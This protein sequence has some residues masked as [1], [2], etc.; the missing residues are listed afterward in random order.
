MQLWQLFLFLSVLSLGLH[1]WQRRAIKGLVAKVVANTKTAL[2][3]GAKIDS[4]NFTL[5]EVVV[6]FSGGGGFTL[7]CKGGRL[8]RSP[9][10]RTNPYQAFAPTLLKTL[11]LTGYNYFNYIDRRGYFC[12]YIC[13]DAALHLR[14]LK[15][16]KE[17]TAR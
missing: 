16:N 5:Q 3:A 1:L 14:E 2:A 11:N 12:S 17:N 4:I 10:A 7:P 6:N 9:M 13:E 15:I 8:A